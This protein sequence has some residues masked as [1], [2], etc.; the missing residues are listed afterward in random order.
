ML[1]KEVQD[2]IIN[3]KADTSKLAF[4]GSPF[5]K[6][7]VQ[8]LIQ[9]IESRRKIEKKLPFWFE[10]ATIIYPPKLNL[11]QTS[12]EATAKYKA[13]LVNGNSMADL[14]GGFGIDT[15][16][17]SER[18]DT[19]IHYELNKELSE[20]AAHNFSVL[21]R[22]NIVCKS[23][24]GMEGFSEEKLN[25]IYVDPS[26]RHNSKGK[27]FFLTDCEPNVVE[28]LGKLRDH[29]DTL[30]IKTSPM[31]DVSAGIDE[32]G[33]PSQLHIVALDN[34][35]KELLWIFENKKDSSTTVFTVNLGNENS[36]SFSFQLNSEGN[37]H[38]GLPQQYLYEPNAAI[39]KS[40]AF[41]LL[42]EAY[43]L[44]KLHINS[45]LYTSENPKSFPGRRFKIEKCIPYT[46]QEMKSGSLPK[47]ANITIRN[48]PESVSTIREKWKIKDGGYDYLFFTTINNNKKVVIYC[49]KL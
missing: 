24:D 38:Y 5:A 34:E 48:F 35:V 44:T 42:S 3:Y 9:Q 23:E 30:M 16:Y 13:S 22:N 45:H 26:R 17:F 6:I 49:S 18:F 31:L 41:H 11:E 29:C 14:T 2:F 28:N 19:V 46:K 25:F 10:K 39:M 7:K 33:A 40:G 43:G 8:E 1:H 32:L 36:E 12:S 37:T 4:A 47:K 21:E 27:V 15:F 20:I